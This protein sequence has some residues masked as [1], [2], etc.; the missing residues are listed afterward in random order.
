MKENISRNITFTLSLTI[1]TTALSFIM[2]KYLLST[3]GDEELGLFR[4]LSQMIFYLALL[5]LGIS[6]SATVAYYKPIIDNDTRK[7][8][9]IFNTIDKFYRKVSIITIIIGVLLIPAIQY[10]IELDSYFMLTCYWLVFVL[11]AAFSFMINRYVILFLADQK[12][13][14]VKAVTGISL[15]LERIFQILIIIEFESFLL[16]IFA[17]IFSNLIRYIFFK[18]KIKNNYNIDLDEIDIDKSIKSDANKMFYH[19]LAHIILYNTDNIIIAK[20]ISLSAVASYSSYLML[21]SLVMTIVSIF[22]SVVD[23]VVGQM[24]IKQS[25]IRNFEL[26]YMLF[27]FSFWIAGFI[28]LGFYYFAT[29]FINNWLG[30]QVTLSQVIVLTIVINLLFDIVKWPTEIIKYKYS[31]YKDIYNPIIEVIINLALSLYLV[32]IYGLIGVIIGTIFV[33]LISNLIVKPIIVFKYCFNMSLIN[34]FKSLLLS[35][36]ELILAVTISYMV[37]SNYHLLGDSLSHSWFDLVFGLSKF[38][39]MYI[40]VWVVIVCFFRSHGTLRQLY[41]F[42]KNKRV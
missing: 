30:E 17:G 2:N 35:L 7:V 6:T 29:P 34:Y 41:L 38:V 15:I 37:F 42:I 22:H 1:I 20:F 36:S 18:R 9:I 11:N 21:T 24:I 10:I 32:Q 3:L 12:V 33:N 16:F 19:K 4:L 25:N 31:Y 14:F 27:R 8:S 40:L 28:G 13:F 5:D 26:W 23:P 39:S